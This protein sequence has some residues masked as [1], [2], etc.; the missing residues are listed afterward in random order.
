MVKP[1]TFED[2]LA[3]QKARELAGRLYQVMRTTPLNSDFALAGQMRRAIIAVMGNLAEGF[4]SPSHAELI[5]H[6][7]VAR[8]QCADLRSQLYLALDAG[9]FDNAVFED[10]RERCTSVS[11][12]I[13]GLRRSLLRLDGGRSSIR[14]S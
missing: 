13:G 1:E 5:R 3:W 2:L 12:L 4:D 11:R 8:M 9:Y 14:P 10:L 6:V 7:E